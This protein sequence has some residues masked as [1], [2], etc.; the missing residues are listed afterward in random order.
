MDFGFLVAAQLSSLFP[1]QAISVPLQTVRQDIPLPQG[2]NESDP[3]AEHSTFSSVLNTETTGTII[4]RV[5]HGGFIIELVSLSTDVVPIRF[6]FPSPIANFPAAFL[7]ESSE[8]HL[9][10]IT[11]TGSL[12]RVVLPIGSSHELWRNQVSNIWPREYVIQS[13]INMKECLVHVHGVHCVAIGLPNG[14]LLRLENDY[15]GAGSDG[16]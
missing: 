4:L 9:I 1:L 12:Y 10:A 14:S 2:P 8:I 15:V 11:E 5:L 6:V 13:P 7:W 3:P 16:K